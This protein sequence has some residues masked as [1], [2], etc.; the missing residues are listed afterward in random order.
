MEDVRALSWEQRRQ[1]L[2]ALAAAWRPPLQIT[3][4]TIDH[5]TATDWM[6]SLA[7]MGIEGAVSKR[8][9]SRYGARGTWSRF[10]C[11]YLAF[12]VGSPSSVGGGCGLLVVGGLAGA[13]ATFLLG[14]LGTF[15]APET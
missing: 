11:P 13:F 3:P 4:Y 8:L 12:F 9:L 10:R 15:L 7:S 2:E 5:A 1:R 6:A 14:G